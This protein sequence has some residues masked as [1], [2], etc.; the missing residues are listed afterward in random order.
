M[1]NG[2]GV[3]KET[4]NVG[5]CVSEAEEMMVQGFRVWC[6]VPMWNG[7]Q[8]PVTPAPAIWSPLLASIGIALMYTHQNPLINVHIILLTKLLIKSMITLRY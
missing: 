1:R 6:L 5:K 2:Y 8:P 4:S 7:S 3:R